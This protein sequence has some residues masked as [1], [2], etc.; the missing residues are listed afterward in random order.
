MNAES[1]AFSSKNVSLAEDHLGFAKFSR[2][3]SVGLVNAVAGF[4]LF[5][6]FFRVLGLDYLL[7]NVLVF[8]SWVWFGFELQRKWSFRAKSSRAAVAKHLLT[9]ITFT[10]FGTTLLWALVEYLG[11][12]PE[13]AYVVT[14]GIVSAG[15]YLVSL[16]WVF[17]DCNQLSE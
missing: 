8:I 14:L 11:L 5:V 15:I 2:F 16:L 4:L 7:A 13:L 3:L 12:F 9:Q 17:R 6:L 10:F 1:R